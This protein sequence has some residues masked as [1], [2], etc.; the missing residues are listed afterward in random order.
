M[1]RGH[2][3]WEPAGQPP[4]P[5][6]L[7]ATAGFRGARRPPAADALPAHDAPLAPRDEAVFLL[8]T[9]A[10]IEHALLVEY[11]YAAFSLGDPSTR[12]DLDAGQKASAAQW[13]GELLDI[14][15][16]EMGHLA[17]V[18]NLLHAIGGPLNFEREDFPFRTEFYPFPFT[19]EPLT[20]DS[21]ARYVATEMPDRPQVPA[22]DQATLDQIVTRATRHNR[23]V[24]INRVGPL[25]EKIAVL[26]RTLRDPEDFRFD[27]ADTVQADPDEWRAPPAANPLEA[28]IVRPVRSKQDALDALDLV[29]KQGEA[30]AAGAGATSHF[31]RFFKLYGD[32][33][34]TNDRYGPV[35]WRPALAVPL[36][37]S[38]RPVAFP[39]DHREAGRITDQRALLWAQ[40]VNLR[41]RMLLAYLAHS[42]HVSRK[43]HPTC[44]QNLVDWTF[45]EMFRLEEISGVNG[46]PGKLTRL[47][48]QAPNL[49]E[50]GRWAVAGPPFELPYTLNLP[51]PER[52]RWGL[53]L[54][55]I[56]A[57]GRLVA[58][59]PRES[60][61][62]ADILKR[63]EDHDKGV[64]DAV[65]KA[66]AGP[67]KDCP[68]GVKSPSGVVRFR[69]T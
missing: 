62:S 15:K 12:A 54:D 9:A 11:L 61:G 69:K 66:M 59:I 24:A 39:D 36:H 28:V 41:Y 67:E 32:F 5:R 50:Q 6:S 30:P 60:D 31:R 43:T 58:L 26:F 16:Q 20:K 4:D 37:P 57:S 35:A 49:Y 7:L 68:A 55:L 2:I 53:H 33:P 65:K 21:V 40:L 19:L 23:F 13:Q 44:R 18:Q 29:A 38:T 48:R 3:R 25:Y 22:G 10:E 47:P 51:V 63:M 45:S 27:T 56:D 17:T 34:E 46:T 1:P 8:H 14:A 42:L 64:G 52:D